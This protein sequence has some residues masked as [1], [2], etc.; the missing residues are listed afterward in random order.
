MR[1][2][3]R[4]QGVTIASHDVVNFVPFP[5]SAI[6]RN[7]MFAPSPSERDVGASVLS[8]LCVCVLLCVCTRASVRTMPLFVWSMHTAKSVIKGM[9]DRVNVCPC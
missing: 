7:S 9:S 8:K 1:A 3:T 5:R 6:R 4:A 2:S